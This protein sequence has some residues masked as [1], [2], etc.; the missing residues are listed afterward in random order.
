MTTLAPIPPEGSSPAVPAGGFK[1]YFK[2]I[3]DWLASLSPTGATAYDTGWVALTAITGNTTTGSARRIG[4]IC[5]LSGDM[6]PGAAGTLTPSAFR[7]M[8]VLPPG[9]APAAT[10][11]MPCYSNTTGHVQARILND[12]TIQVILM[13]GQANVAITTSTLF[14][15]SYASWVIN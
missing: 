12:G 5:K 4:R 1:A 6:R 10:M 7:D 2:R 11:L 15:F 8:A 9:M 14:S 13:A 3:T